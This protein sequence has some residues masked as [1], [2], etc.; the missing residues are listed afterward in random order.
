MLMTP[1]S[2]LMGILM[3]LTAVLF[4]MLGQGGGAVYTPLQVIF[5]IDFH[6]AATTSLFLI[7][8]GAIA[9]LPVYQRA[10]LIDWPLAL[11]LEAAA[12]AGGFAGGMVSGTFSQAFLTLTFALLVAC[13]AGLMIA[14]LRVESCARLPTITTMCWQRRHGNHNYKVNLLLGLPLAGLAGFASGLLGIGGG[15]FLVPLMVLVLGVPMEIAVG[16]S[17][18]MVGL[19]AASGFSGHLFA[20]HWDWRTSILLAVIV[21]LGAR[22]GAQLSVQ[23]DKRLIQRFFGLVLM[24][25][26]GLMVARI[27]LT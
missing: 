4:A 21:F 9:A 23:T 15:M 24:T 19:T 12:V 5:G 27:V 22:L 25:L 16:S 14:D 17:S 1:V 13:V 8:S 26:A 18:L 10:G 6:I 20:G 11:T 3:F 2:A 7:M